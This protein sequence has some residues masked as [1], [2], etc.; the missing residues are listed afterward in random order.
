[1]ELEVGDKVTISSKASHEFILGEEVEIID[2]CNKGLESLHYEA[3][4]KSGKWWI[5]HNDYN[6]KTIIKN[7]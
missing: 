3:K 5:N 1:M 4:G 7:K 2:V 6:S